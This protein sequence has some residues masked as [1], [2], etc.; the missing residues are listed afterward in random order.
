MSVCCVWCARETQS[1]V[2]FSLE[3]F[4]SSRMPS[5][6]FYK[7]L[8]VF[9]IS[10]T[11][12][13]D[14]P[15]FLFYLSPSVCACMCSS[16]CVCLRQGAVFSFIPQIKCEGHSSRLDRG[17]QKRENKKRK[18]RPA[19]SLYLAA[20]VCKWEACKDSSSNRKAFKL[21]FHSSAAGL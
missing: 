2:K 4:F 10:P 7:P 12:I 18:C 9:V 11:Q 20:S 1:A 8:G 6:I 17:E 3:G 19:V 13:I 16:R 14:C 5:C 15:S 21:L